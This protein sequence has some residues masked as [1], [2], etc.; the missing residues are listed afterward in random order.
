M[1]MSFSFTVQMKHRMF[2]LKIKPFLD[3]SIFCGRI[4]LNELF[5]FLVKQLV[6]AYEIGLFLVLVKILL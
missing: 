3:I 4:I 2:S 6:F 5:L 1:A